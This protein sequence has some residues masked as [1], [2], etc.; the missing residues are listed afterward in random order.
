[1]DKKG[2]G[3]RGIKIPMMRGREKEVNSEIKRE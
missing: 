2:L 3:G 1:M